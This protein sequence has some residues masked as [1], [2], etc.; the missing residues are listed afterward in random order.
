MEKNKDHDCQNDWQHYQTE[1]TGVLV[2]S[3]GLFVNSLV[4]SVLLAFL[5]LSQGQNNGSV[6][7]GS[8]SESGGEMR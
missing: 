5:V 3:T 8:A 7:S 4:F 6:Q 2:S 1:F